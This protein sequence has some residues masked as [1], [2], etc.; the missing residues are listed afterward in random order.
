MGFDKLAADLLG[1]SVLIRSM[2]AMEACPEVAEIRVIVS[3]AA[4]DEI[5]ALVARSGISK[6]IEAVPGGA[7]RHLS[8]WAGLERV[9]DDCPLVA[10]H[11]AARPLVSVEAISRCAAVAAD[12]GAAALAHR[13]VDTLKRANPDGEVETAVERENLWAMETPQIFSLSLL[14]KA[15]ASVL[16]R[17]MVVT[18]E[19]TAV[20]ESGHSVKLVENGE[21]NLKITVPSDLELAAAI[22]QI[23]QRRARETREARRARE[24][25]DCGDGDVGDDG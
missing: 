22:L 9:P 6:F 15:Y 12:H 24:A 5:T 25:S 18:D 4:V 11:D 21:P 17:G 3:P 14:R 20:K 13:V 8:V 16:E 10:V 2:R 7:E 23:R 19:V 1:E